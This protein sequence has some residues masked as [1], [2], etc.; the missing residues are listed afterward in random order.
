MLP[1]ARERRHDLLDLHRQHLD[2]WV[3]EAKRPRV[4]VYGQAMV[5][6]RGADNDYTLGRQ[7]ENRTSKPPVCGTALCLMLRIGP[8]SDT[9]PLAR[10][11]PIRRGLDVRVPNIVQ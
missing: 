9:G 4:E 6:A 10:L 3:A 1:N 2:R 8:Q 7:S 5:E 11:F